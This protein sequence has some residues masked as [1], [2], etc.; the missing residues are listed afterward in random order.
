MAF[1]GTYNFSYYRGDT[2]S[3]NVFP[4]DS[5]GAVFSL[6]EYVYEKSPAFT[7]ST[8]RGDAGIPDQIKCFAE[9]S[10]DFTHI[11]CTI[12]PEDGEKMQAGV[13]YVYD[14]EISR[15]SS[16][17]DIV[18]TLLTGNISV[19]DQVTMPHIQEES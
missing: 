11:V 8:A 19:T 12:R 10:D 6:E 14:I 7:I 4:K 2:L 13:S 1:P 3:F 5:S 9:I 18:H 17:Y 15:P 16:P